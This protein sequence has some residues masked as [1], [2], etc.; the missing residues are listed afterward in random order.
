MGLEHFAGCGRIVSTIVPSKCVL[1]ADNYLGETP[2]WSARERVLYWINCEQSP[3]IHRWHFD[4]GKHDVWPM[5]RRVGG[6]VL[7]Q[8]GGLLV[9]LGDGLYDFDP[10]TA[11]LVRRIESPLPPHVLLHECQCDRQ[12]RFWVGGYDHH[13]SAENPDSRGAAWLRLDGNVLTPVITNIGVSNGLAFSPDG[14]VMYGADAPTARVEAFDLDIATGALS[15]RR[16]FFQLK[17]GEGYPDG[18]AVDAEGGYWI[19]AV[20]AGQLR[21]YL[22]D[23]ALDRIV[24][25]PFSNPTKLAFG[26]PELDVIYVTSTQLPITLPGVPGAERNGGLFAVYAGITGL[27]DPRISA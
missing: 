15:N 22:P 21:R 18:A 1:A 17:E 7:K 25:L 11:R 20:A 23:G 19:A 3:E 8:A 5:P 24:D 12:G 16:T 10:K 9:V 27:E 4:T 13:L 2:L 14:R 6:I 26:G